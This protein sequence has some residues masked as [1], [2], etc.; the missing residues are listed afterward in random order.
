MSPAA[1]R[2]IRSVRGVA[3]TIRDH[4]AVA[5]TPKIHPSLRQLAFDSE[6]YTRCIHWPAIQH[7]HSSAKVTHALPELELRDLSSAYE[8]YKRISAAGHYPQLCWEVSA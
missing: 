5:A 7:Q 6:S 3:A 4:L 1:I 8:E 2:S